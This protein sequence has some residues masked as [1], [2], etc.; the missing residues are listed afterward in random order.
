MFRQVKGRAFE[1][2]MHP[3]ANYVVAALVLI[4]THEQLEQIAK[5]LLVDVKTLCVQQHSVC[6]VDKVISLIQDSTLRGQ[7]VS[8]LVSDFIEIIQSPYGNYAFN[9]ALTEFEPALLEPIY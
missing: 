5:E 4:F 3:K 1:L 8:G 9:T 7:F 6:I 2:T